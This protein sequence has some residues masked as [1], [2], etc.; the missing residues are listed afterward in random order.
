MHIIN[1]IIVLK[2]ATSWKITTWTILKYFTFPQFNILGVYY[3]VR[4]VGG[5]KICD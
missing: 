4:R 3:Y 2:Y 1:N 5:R